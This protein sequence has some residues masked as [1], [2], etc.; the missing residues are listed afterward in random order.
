MSYDRMPVGM[1]FSVG[2][3]LEEIF[4]GLY[5]GPNG[6]IQGANRP[7][8]I[9]GELLLTEV[10]VDPSFQG[11]YLPSK[12]LI[13]HYMQD[14]ALPNSDLGSILK[15][16]T[17]GRVIRPIPEDNRYTANGI[18]KKGSVEAVF[19]IF[20]IYERSTLSD[21]NLDVPKELEQR[22]GHVSR[23][24]VLLPEEIHIGRIYVPR[25]VVEK[26]TNHTPTRHTARGARPARYEKPGRTQ[27][28]EQQQAHM[29]SITPTPHGQAGAV[30]SGR[31]K[32]LDW[33]RK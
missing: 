15:K 14:K 24:L 17:A 19:P 5:T 31:K 23:A 10:V 20:D 21:I 2:P 32:G 30:A 25:H 28:T 27:V 3:V 12:A 22:L 18:D 26:L 11:N 6:K 16:F 7:G 13:K 4:E 1:E 33:R 8:F 9:S 29:D